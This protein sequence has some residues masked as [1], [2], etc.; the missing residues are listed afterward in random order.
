MVYTLHKFS[1]P[2]LTCNG[3]VERRPY[4]QL[5]LFNGILLTKVSQE[6]KEADVAREVG[7]AEASKDPQVRLEQGEQ[8]L[9][10][11]LVHVTP[12]VLF[13]GVIHELVHIAL[14]CSIAARRV[15]VEPAAR[16]DGE[17]RRLLHRLHREI[18]GRMDD[19]S[20]LTTDPGNNRGPVFVIMAPLGL[21]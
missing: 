13:L 14:E 18:F 8:T 3:G 4:D 9:R 12:G 7:F 21:A 15:R 5:R 16:L 1:S 19:H 17:V 6:L 11:M 20:S 2:S 10:P